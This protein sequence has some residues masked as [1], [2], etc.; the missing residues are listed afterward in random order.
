MS[1]IRHLIP[2][3]HVLGEASSTL[4]FAGQFITMAA[5]QFIEK[6]ADDS[7]TNASWNSEKNWLIGNEINSPYGKIH[8]A[9]DYPLLALLICDTQLKP[10]VEIELVG[11]TQ[12]EAFNWLNN[13]F[14]KLGLEVEYFEMQVHY[15]LPDHPITH[16]AAFEMNIAKHFLELANYRSNGH[17]ALNKSSDAF[18]DKSELK[19]WPHHF[20]E[21]VLLNISFSNKLPSAQ[22]SMGLAIPDKYYTQPYFYVNPWKLTGFDSSNPSSLKSKGKWHTDE[23][24]GQVL[25][26]DSFSSIVLHNEQEDIVNEFFKEAIQNCLKLL[27]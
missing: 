15:E 12:L 11:K 18:K 26:A 24:F 3:P 5:N 9:L 21:G 1:W 13:Q 27:R 14:W 16:G 4:Y 19:V 10:I 6:K 7:H 8:I 17:Y 2:D 22:I 20:D 23:W 25:T